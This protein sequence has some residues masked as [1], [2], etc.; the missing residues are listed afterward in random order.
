MLSLSS[1]D[2]VIRESWL[3]EPPAILLPAYYAALPSTYDVKH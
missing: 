2:A 1:C 3:R